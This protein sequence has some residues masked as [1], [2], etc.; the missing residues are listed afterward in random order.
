MA[1]G[2]ICP[3]AYSSLLYGLE[4]DSAGAEAFSQGKGPER[5]CSWQDAAAEGWDGRSRHRFSG[6]SFVTNGVSVLRESFPG[7]VGFVPQGRITQVDKLILA[8]QVTEAVLCA[9]SA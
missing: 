4:A 1:S 5:G 9:K 8:T 6:L 3:V 2:Q 7:A